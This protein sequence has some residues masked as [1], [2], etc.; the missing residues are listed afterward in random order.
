MLG[1]KQGQEQGSLDMPPSKMGRGDS[2]EKI[3]EH[4]RK[5]L[6]EEPQVEGDKQEV[7]RREVRPQPL[8]YLVGTVGNPTIPRII[9]REKLENA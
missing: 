1:G 2:G 9:V 8:E 5:L 4:L 3:W 7:P 6:Q